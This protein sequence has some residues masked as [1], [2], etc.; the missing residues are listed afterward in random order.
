MNKQYN[1]IIYSFNE[2]ILMDLG[3]GS[4]PQIRLMAIAN[5]KLNYIVRDWTSLKSAKNQ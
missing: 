1:I 4:H 5:Y 3:G 2:Q